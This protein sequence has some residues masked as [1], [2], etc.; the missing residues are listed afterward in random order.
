MAN[1]F[2]GM[3]FTN[4]ARR[5]FRAFNAA[6]APLFAFTTDFSNEVVQGTVVTTR[7][8]PVSDA[9]VDLQ[10]GTTIPGDRE[11]TAVVKD[12]TTTPVTVT[13]NQQPATGFTL[14]DDEA[15]KIGSGVWEDTKNNLII[16][17]AYAVA[18]HML[19][20]VFNLITNANFSG[21]VHTGAASAW[22]LDDIVDIGVALKGTHKWQVNGDDGILGSMV[23]DSSYWGATKKDN[24]IQDVSASGIPVVRTGTVNKVD[25]FALYE[26]PTLPPAAGTPASENLTGFVAKPSAIAIAMRIVE[27]QARDKLMHFEV[28][29]DPI[30]GV[31]LVYSAHYHTGLRKV[32][33]IFEAW[34]GASKGQAEALKR[35]VS[36]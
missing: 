16:N 12:I 29:T 27:S 5:G 3:T 10:T 34:Y 23:L 2:N 21:A 17:K 33:H 36:V 22:D 31:T 4:I 1:A 15:I 25:Q 7:I 20:Y 11:D 14:S 8:T 18:K 19:D 9:A 6:L 35:I 24:A 26:A 13:L 28:M 32:Y 30:T